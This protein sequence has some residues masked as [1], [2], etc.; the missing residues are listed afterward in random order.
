MTISRHTI[1][2]EA[3]GGHYE[4]QGSY[5][6]QGSWQNDPTPTTVWSNGCEMAEPSLTS[7]GWSGSTGVTTSWV[8]SNPHTG[9]YSWYLAYNASTIGTHTYS[10]VFAGLQ[11]GR[12]YRIALWARLGGSGRRLKVGVA[13][14]SET[15][16]LTTT[17]TWTELAVTFVATNAQHQVIVTV[18]RTTANN[19]SAQLDDLKLTATT[20]WVP[21]LVWVPN[22][23]WVT[24][25]VPLSVIDADITLDE[26]WSPYT[27]ASLVCWLPDEG[28]EDIDPRNGSRVDF[29]LT[30]SF[31]TP[32]VPF[33][34]LY[35]APIEREFSLALRVR[36][37]DHVTGTVRLELASGE[38]GLQD[39]AL[40]A[41][42]P[43]SP[44]STDVRTITAWVLERIGAT[45]ET[46]TET[47]TVEAD[48]TAWQ[49]GVT[50]WDYLRPLLDAAELR[51]WCDELGHWYLTEPLRGA[52]GGLILSASG[53][54]TQADD[55][56][57][58]E[59]DW[60]DAVVITYRWRDS[61]D[62]EHVVYD[63]A[64]LSGWSKVLPITYERP[65]PGNGAAA[66]ILARAKGRGRRIGIE[67]INDYAATPGQAV[68]LVL[69]DTPI[70]TGIL[71]SVRW[72]LPDDEMKV[73]SR[74]LIDTPPNSWVYTPA[75]TA[76]NEVP[77]GTDWT[78]YVA[79]I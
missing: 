12:T 72:R 52:E 2:A 56:I 77:P 71:S 78:D 15:A 79:A 13:G 25:T 41:A 62:V 31:G 53:T 36:E 26:G 35:R 23:V 60:Y 76:W 67:A 55:A 58:R 44:S 1:T 64:S 66:A 48:A 59:R 30:Q 22:V 74:D 51:L 16:W 27:Q 6:D 20:E 28:F 49:P 54:V 24:T 19:G 40:V 39:Y 4:D 37:I 57:D 43:A 11:V 9:T 3:V 29:T 63:T 32:E 5:V 69:E 73:S 38:A 75:G 7:E 68:T 18:E 45:L 10:K 33:N 47:G 34:A 50:A 21:N 61:S 46:G 17:G 70:Q 65:W 42:A 8:T 14:K